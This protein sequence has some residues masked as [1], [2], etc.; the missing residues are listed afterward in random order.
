[1]IGTELLPDIQLALRIKRAHLLAGGYKWRLRTISVETRQSVIE[2]DQ[3][4]CRECG[5]HREQVDHIRGNDNHLANLQLL[6][7]ECHNRKTILRIKKISPEADPVAWA[8]A[9]E[10]R[11]RVES[12]EALRVCDVDDWGKLWR[13][14]R[15]RR[16]RAQNET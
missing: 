1:M 11:T 15:G 8:K 7:R 12:F 14:I 13:S 2:R 6:C 4:V 3:G 5:G 16:L 10:L 9:E